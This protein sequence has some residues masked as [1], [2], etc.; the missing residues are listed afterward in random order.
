MMEIR[1]SLTTK[2]EATGILLLKVTVGAGAP[3]HYRI[4][5]HRF[6]QRLRRTIDRS[7]G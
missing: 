4:H 3:N 1:P 6:E 2:L 5:C 7:A